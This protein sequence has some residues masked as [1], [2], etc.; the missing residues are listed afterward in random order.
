MAVRNPPAP[1]KATMLLVEP[2]T[3]IDKLNPTCRRTFER[4]AGSSVTARQREVTVEH[5]LLALLDE[6]ESDFVALLDHYRIDTTDARASLQKYVGELASG[7]SGRPVFSPTLFEWLQD[8]WVHASAELGEAALRSGPLL[9]R[10]LLAP[11][12]Y[13][14]IEL[15][16]FDAIPRDELRKTLGTLTA[17]TPEAKTTP[18]FTAPS[19]DGG[20]AGATSESALSRFATNL[21]ERAKEGK[22]DPVFGREAE[23]RQMVDI[24][25]RRRKNNPILVGEPGVGKTA[26]VE[27]L[28]L[29]IAEGDIPEALLN[30]QVVTLDRCAPGGRRREGRIRTTAPIGDRGGQSEPATDYLVH[31]RS[32]HPH[33]GR[34]S[35]GRRRRSEPPEA[36]AG[37]R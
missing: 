23:V 13:T 20:A 7:N 21:T 14:A 17:H 31:R 30:T 26:L 9:L 24:L 10:L 3:L 6:R 25:C 37:A 5:V 2:R 15:P 28:A 22:L 19:G 1:P 35:A 18:Q 16:G 11:I 33:R 36:R 34:W 29:R 32:T 12:R 4:A 8:A 27:G